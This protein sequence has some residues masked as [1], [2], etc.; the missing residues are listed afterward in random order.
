MNTNIA[1]ANSKFSMD[2]L[3]DITVLTCNEERL[4]LDNGRAVSKSI[5]LHTEQLLIDFA[6]SIQSS[7][8]NLNRDF[9]AGSI[10]GSRI[11][12]DR[13]FNWHASRSLSFM[14]RTGMYPIRC[15]NPEKKGSKRYIVIPD[16]NGKQH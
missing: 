7:G 4:K 6:D 16:H 15:I 12:Y 5:F 14:E 9:D 3:K 10:L 11:R 1:K 8:L 2:Y 13:R